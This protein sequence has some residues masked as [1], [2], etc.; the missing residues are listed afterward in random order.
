[1]RMDGIGYRNSRLQYK[2]LRSCVKKA[3]TRSLSP[4]YRGLNNVP[5]YIGNGNF[6]EAMKNYGIKTVCADNAAK[7]HLNIPRLVSKLLLNSHDS[8]K[9]PALDH[10]LMQ[11]FGRTGVKVL[12]DEE[13]N[14]LYFL[15][16][17]ENLRIF[18]TIGS[19]PAGLRTGPGGKDCPTVN[20]LRR[21]MKGDFLGE[22]KEI[23]I[24]RHV[25]NCERCLNIARGM[26][27]VR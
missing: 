9:K 4:E 21:L 8:L 12:I 18:T 1:M 22:S 19:T 7:P 6:Q 10:D 5:Q 13:M 24:E 16:S 3:F 17:K 15:R 23:E 2:V 20:Q 14:K 25:E 11:I 26:M 27:S